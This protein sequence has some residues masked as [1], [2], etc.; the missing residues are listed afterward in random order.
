MGEERKPLRFA[1]PRERRGWLLRATA[2]SLF[3]AGCL[4]LASHAASGGSLAGI[5]ASLL[6]LFGFVLAAVA[7]IRRAVAR[8][9]PLVLDEHGV[10]VD[11]GP[12]GRWEL[13]WGEVARVRLDDGLFR[14]RVVLE[15]SGESD[16]RVIPACCHGGLPP[17]WLAGLIET[18]RECGGR[19]D[20]LTRT[21]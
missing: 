14:R 10:R 5:A 9:P 19:L 21:A 7:A 18:F 1:A 4:P 6:G 20:R 13:R 2:A 17:E 16:P 12:G 3:A 11:V 15:V 8:R